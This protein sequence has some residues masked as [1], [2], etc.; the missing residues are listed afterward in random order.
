MIANYE[1]LII[2]D[3]ISDLGKVVLSIHY[4]GIESY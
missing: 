2:R 1:A 4:R 3:G